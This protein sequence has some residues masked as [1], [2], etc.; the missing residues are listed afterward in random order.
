MCKC[1]NCGNIIKPK[2][3]HGQI[4]GAVIL[5]ILALFPGILYSV[6]CKKV[7]CPVCDNNAYEKISKKEIERGW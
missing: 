5:M 6:F 7:T 3:S 2:M 1:K 4:F